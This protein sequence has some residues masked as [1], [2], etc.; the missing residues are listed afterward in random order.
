M[1][2]RLP[3][4]LPPYPGE[5]VGFQ[6]FHLD[7]QFPHPFDD[8]LAVGVVER[9]RGGHHPA[10]GPAARG[11]GR[12]REAGQVA[13]LHPFAAGVVRRGGCVHGERLVDVDGIRAGHRAG[14]PVAVGIPPDPPIGD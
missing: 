2:V 6:V 9:G 1:R 13:G 7:A 12:R 5:P 11:P 14:V 10:G 3:V 4:G 8:P